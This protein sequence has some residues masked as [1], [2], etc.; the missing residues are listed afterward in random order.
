MPDAP[1]PKFSVL[2][3]ELTIAVLCRN[4]AETISM[5]LQD[6]HRAAPRSR[7]LVIDNG[8]TDSSGDRAR[9]MGAQVVFVPELGFGHAWRAVLASVETPWCIVTDGDGEWPL[10][11]TLPRLVDEFER[12]GADFLLGRRTRSTRPWYNAK[13]GSPALTWLAR[14]VRGI[15]LSDLHAGVRLFRTAS[16]RELQI[17][18]HGMG[19]QTELVLRANKLGL[20]LAEGPVT[21]APAASG[22]KSYLR[23]IRDGLVC[24]ALTLGGIEVLDRL[25]ELRRKPA[26][27]CQR[28]F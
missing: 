8:S 3:D 27:G 26:S 4:E 23:P 28:G 7:L 17:R 15:P 6:A 20:I 12:S 1:S 21:M 14:C 25:A 18:S 24:A 11:P 19:A 10:E 22:R 5:V 16:I 13:L 2:P 9:E